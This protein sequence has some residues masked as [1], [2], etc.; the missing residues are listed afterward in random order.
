M[1]NEKQSQVEK[2]E[3]GVFPPPHLL[4]GCLAE[5]EF[6]QNGFLRPIVDAVHPSHPFHLIRHFECFHNAFRLFHLRDYAFHP[7]LAGL[8]NLAQVG[9]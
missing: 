3:T 9:V 1:A 7:I 6:A 4:I 5:N 8:L 2:K